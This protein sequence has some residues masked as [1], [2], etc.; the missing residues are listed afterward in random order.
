MRSIS[1]PILSAAL[2][3]LL[4][5]GVAS[6]ARAVCEGENTE[7][8]DADDAECLE[9]SKENTI[10]RPII[11]TY[12]VKNLCSSLGTV[13]AGIDREKRTDKTVTLSDDQSVTESISGYLSI[14]CC[15]NDTNMCNRSDKITTQKCKTAWGNSPAAATCQTR[16]A[17]VSM[18]DDYKCYISTLCDQPR[19]TNVQFL[20]EIRNKVTVS[21][22]DADDLN[23][24]SGY[25]RKTC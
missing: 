22:H 6:Q 21:I 23:N 25:L 17:Y 3:M 20:P 4:V 15:K 5:T 8:I 19:G 10:H 11:T 18:T 13:V 16:N 2:A 9:A 14:K 12:T 7:T 1:R 24:C